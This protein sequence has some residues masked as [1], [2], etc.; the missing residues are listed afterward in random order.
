[1]KI[2][3]VAPANSSHIVKWCKWFNNHGHETHVISFIPG[4]IEGTQ[5]HT[6]DLSVNAEGSDLEKLR[7]LFSGKRIRNLIIEIRPD[8]INAHYATSYGIAMALSGIKGYVLSVWGS[9]VYDFPRKSILH[10]ALLQY[11]FMKAS[12]LF[13]TS[14]AMA[15]EAN[16]YTNKEFTITPFGVDMELFNPNKRTREGDRPFIIGTVKTMSSLYGID[17]ILKAVGILKAKYHNIDIY[18]RISGDGPQ[19]NEYKELAKELSIDE[20]TLFLGRITQE[21]AANEWAN[22]DAAIIPSIMYESFG[23][24]AVEAQASGTP[25]IVSEVGGLLETTEPGISS[26]VVNRKDEQAIADAILTLYHD[27]SLREKM[28]KAGRKNVAIKYELNNCFRYIEQ[29]LMKH[30]L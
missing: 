5:V 8:V 15:K 6:I 11:S 9:D 17:Y 12:Q 26:I 13:S 3:F 30:R 28:G 25:V 20:I 19:A 24:A 16:K 10:R 29:E 18:V 7:Y 21:E 1:M 27:P 14:H 22:M 2:C 23:V 4:K